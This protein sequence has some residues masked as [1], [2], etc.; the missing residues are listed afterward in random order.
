MLQLNLS[1]HRNFLLVR[2]RNNGNILY[3][4]NIADTIGIVERRKKER[5]N[6]S[7]E[8]TGV[9]PSLVKKSSLRKEIKSYQIWPGKSFHPVSSKMPEWNV[10]SL[11]RKVHFCYKIACQPKRLGMMTNIYLRNRF[12]RIHLRA[13]MVGNYTKGIPPV[14]KKEDVAF[15][16]RVDSLPCMT[17][18]EE[19]NSHWN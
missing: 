9:C 15:L 18:E 16:Y 10:I 6:I 2:L 1:I 12:Q 3:E 7:L 11:R 19:T 8:T 14:Y 13:L 5:C 17:S 4:T